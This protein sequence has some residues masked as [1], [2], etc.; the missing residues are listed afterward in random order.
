M[1]YA[2]TLIL[3]RSSGVISESILLA[4]E[5]LPLTMFAHF[6]LESSVTR[7]FDPKRAKKFSKMAQFGAQGYFTSE[8][9]F[10]TGFWD[11]RAV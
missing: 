8:I 1:L 6:Y 5:P 4:G 2:A 10:G 11:F 3:S 7:S 9:V